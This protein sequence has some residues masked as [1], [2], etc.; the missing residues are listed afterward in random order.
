MSSFDPNLGPAKFEAWVHY[1][2]ATYTIHPTLR[3]AMKHADTAV[4]ATGVRFKLPTA[5]YVL[6]TKHPGGYWVAHT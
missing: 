6:L 4:G 5:E 2:D 1:V 3:D